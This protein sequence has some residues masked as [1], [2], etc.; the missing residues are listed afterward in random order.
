MMNAM[1]SISIV[2]IGVKF[3]PVNVLPVEVA[4]HHH[5]GS[6]VWLLC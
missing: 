2:F 4:A 1:I 6:C 3:L 5:R